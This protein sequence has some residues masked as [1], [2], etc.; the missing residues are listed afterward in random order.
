MLRIFKVKNDFTDSV[1][2]RRQIDESYC[3]GAKY[4]RA[5]IANKII[6]MLDKSSNEMYDKTAQQ[7]LRFIEKR[8]AWKR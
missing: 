8:N 6:E 5:I 4:E 1:A 7:I 2:Y 3:D